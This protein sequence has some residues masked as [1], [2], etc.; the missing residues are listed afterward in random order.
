MESTI[1]HK[2][3]TDLG[4]LSFVATASCQIPGQESP[5]QPRSVAY[6][7]LNEYRRIWDSYG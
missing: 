6:L 1:I 3:A 7:L 2:Y 5:S 4:W